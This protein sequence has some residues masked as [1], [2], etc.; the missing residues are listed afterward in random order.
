MKLQNPQLRGLFKTPQRKTYTLGGV[1]II[2]VALFILF[3]IRPT[4]VKIGELNKEIA[5]NREF[6]E[7][8]EIKYDTL[9]TLIQKKQEASGDIAYFETAFP[10]AK[11]SG[12][13]VANLAAI[14]EQNGLVLSY[15][16]FKDVDQEEET[17]F[18]IENIDR[19]IVSKVNL[20]LKG[21]LNDIE[22]F[23]RHMEKFPR[24][25]DIISVSYEKEDISESR[26][27]TETYYPLECFISSY[28][29][30]WIGYGEELAEE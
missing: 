26:Y 27:S 2:V 19:V 18:E 4:F 14:A 1:T 13:M 5:E 16:E 25:Y 22:N 12:F 23:V 30:E 15:V 24:I 10:E 29:F 7:D 9:T 3:T 6:L 28:I 20:S 17:F 8:L 21:D 11:R